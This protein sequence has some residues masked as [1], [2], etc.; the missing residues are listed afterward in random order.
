MYMIYTTLLKFNCSLN[1]SSI[2]KLRNFT[3]C[4]VEVEIARSTYK[5]TFYLPFQLRLAHSKISW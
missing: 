5:H 1:L 4:F 2:E 3:V